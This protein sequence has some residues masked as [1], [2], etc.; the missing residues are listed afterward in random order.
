MEPSPQR[1][2]RRLPAESTRERRVYRVTVELDD[3]APDDFFSNRDGIRG[4]RHV[5]GKHFIVRSDSLETLQRLGVL[6][7]IRN[8]NI[9]DSVKF[10][11]AATGR[12]RS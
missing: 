4:T 12:R 5:Y 6:R 7:G 11:T 9:S 10:A 2:G 3:N 8:V 1:D